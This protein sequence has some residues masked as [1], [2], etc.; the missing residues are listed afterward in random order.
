[1]YKKYRINPMSLYIAGVIMALSIL[2]MV[3]IEPSA[4]LSP[5]EMYQ[6]AM[7]KVFYSVLGVTGV[8]ILM[9]HTIY[10]NKKYFRYKNKCVKCSSPVNRE[11]DFYCRNCGSEL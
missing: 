3:T 11:T 10:A 4:G 9:G 6:L 7:A 8:V 5:N 2:G 1:M